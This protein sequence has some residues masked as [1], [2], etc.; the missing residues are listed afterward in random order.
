MSVIGELEPPVGTSRHRAVKYMLIRALNDP[1]LRRRHDQMTE[2]HDYDSTGLDLTDEMKSRLEVLCAWSLIS[3]DQAR[4]CID[5]FLG[6]DKVS[7]MELAEEFG[8]DERTIR[9]WIA[10]GIREMVTRIYESG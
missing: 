2:R 9:R 6:P 1:R 5:R 8:K 7:Q 10:G 3:D 4:Y